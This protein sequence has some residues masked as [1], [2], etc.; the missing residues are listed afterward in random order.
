MDSQSSRHFYSTSKVI[1]IYKQPSRN[2]DSHIHF[3]VCKSAILEALHFLKVGLMFWKKK[4]KQNEVSFASGKLQLWRVCDYSPHFIQGAT[5]S[6]DGRTAR[7]SEH[8][9]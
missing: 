9:I 5:T 3:H 7:P 6:I 8:F 2:M 1:Y 4:K